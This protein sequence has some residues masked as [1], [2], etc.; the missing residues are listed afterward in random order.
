MAGKSCGTGYSAEKN[1]KSGGKDCVKCSET[2]CASGY[3]TTVT[4]CSSADGYKLETKGASG[5]KVCGKCVAAACPSGYTA[6]KNGKSDGKDCVKC[7]E[8]PC[9]S[10]YSTATVSCDTGY[11]LETK[12]ASGT[13][14]CG[15]CV[16]QTCSQMG[17]NKSCSSG[18]YSAS[19][20][21]SGSDGACTTCKACDS[22]CATCSGAGASSCKTCPS[23]YCLKNG[24][25]IENVCHVNNCARCECGVAFKCVSGWQLTA[26]SC[27][28]KNSRKE[29]GKWL[30][31]ACY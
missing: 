26:N 16:Q 5:A 25:C 8:T 12:G 2:P 15:K 22:S 17:Y 20:G 4:S 11:K 28:C 29:N 21:V 6:E 19:A 23:G 31:G 1:G 27:D 14:A 24:K 9:A 3:S 13:K 10:G 7:I 18:Q 30:Q